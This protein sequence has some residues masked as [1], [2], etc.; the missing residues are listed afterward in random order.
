MRRPVNFRKCIKWGWLWA[1]IMEYK[2]ETVSSGCLLSDV[3]YGNSNKWSF[4]VRFKQYIGKSN[5]LQISRVASNEVDLKQTWWNPNSKRFEKADVWTMWL[6]V[7]QKK[8]WGFI[9]ELKNNEK[10]CQFQEI[11]QTSWLWAN[12]M[13]YKL[14]TV[15]SGCLLNDVAYRTQ[16][17]LKI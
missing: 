15:W 11:H 3:A 17:K 16:K 13:E 10:T 9:F 4:I 6:T 8:K 7:T 2:L 5:D 14:E 12:I 1:N